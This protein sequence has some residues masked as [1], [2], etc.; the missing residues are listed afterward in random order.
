MATLEEEQAN[1]VVL[2]DK[3]ANPVKFRPSRPSPEQSHQASQ[4]VAHA[5]TE[6]LTN[7]EPSAVLQLNIY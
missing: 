6:F 2:T 5:K 4:F 7:S 3:E 1:R